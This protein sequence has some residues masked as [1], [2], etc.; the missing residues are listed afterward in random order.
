MIAQDDPNFNAVR[1]AGL[2]VL[3]LIAVAVATGDPGAGVHGK[4]LAITLAVVAYLVAATG[5]F[6]LRRRP[7]LQRLRFA[8]LMLL[9][10]ASGALL[11]LQP[12]GAAIAGFFAAAGTAGVRARGRSSIA[13]LVGVLVVA[14]VALIASGD[15]H[16]AD[17]VADN[18]GF[19]MIFLVTRLSSEAR[20]GRVRAE[21]LL[22]ELEESRDALVEAAAL[23]ERGRIARDLHDVL[24]H[25][26]SA[27]SVQLEGTRLLARSRGADDDV[28]DAIE[29]AHHLAGSG[30][31]E[32]RRAISALR[33]DDLPG[34]D[35][36]AALVQSFEEQAGI[37]CAFELTGTPRELS[38]EARI[39]VYRTAQEALTN[40]R[41]HADAERV[42][43]RLHYDEDGTTLVVE[44]HARAVVRPGGGGTAVLTDS[45]GGYGLS[46]MR[47]RAELLD[48]RL[49][50][51]PTGAGFRVELWLPAGSGDAG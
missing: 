48:G 36:L 46:G 44:D 43:L 18:V 5:G 3:A 28:V 26:L 35:L 8:A 41:K 42:E 33:G 10:L 1:R 31:D 9:V 17:I 30:L 23:R 40:V 49:S 12:N 37:D 34:P 45:G 6:A 51:A 13:I 22:E 50:A 4:R 21:Q 29:R 7:G 14:N 16:A 27:L 19:V 25:S 38:S 20:A 24:A 47:E 39:A 32:A 11:Y 15:K 2:V